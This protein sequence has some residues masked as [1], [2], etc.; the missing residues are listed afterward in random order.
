MKS[1]ILRKEAY[2]LA[3]ETHDALQGEPFKGIGFGE[4]LLLQKSGA[5]YGNVSIKAFLHERFSMQEV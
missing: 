2:N 5:F 1:L 3:C 4:H